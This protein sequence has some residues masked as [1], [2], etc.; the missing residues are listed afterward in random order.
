MAVGDS[1]RWDDIIGALDNSDENSRR[2]QRKVGAEKVTASLQG[3]PGITQ[4]KEVSGDAEYIYDTDSD[5]SDEPEQNI[6][7]GTVTI[8]L[9]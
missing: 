3:T 1:G 9:K 7:T 6:A 8:K 5:D 2:H 4:H